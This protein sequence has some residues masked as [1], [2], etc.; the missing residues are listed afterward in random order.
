MT[1][2]AVKREASLLF[3]SSEML[4]SEYLNIL[5]VLE[6]VYVQHRTARA[7]TALM[8]S[9]MS[10]RNPHSF[11]QLGFSSLSLSYSFTLSSFSPQLS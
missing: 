8:C 6:H 3:Y 2:C 4:V 9:G 5:L 1:I 11:L 10:P 7:L